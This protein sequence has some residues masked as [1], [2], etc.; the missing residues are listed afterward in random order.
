M[1]FGVWRGCVAFAVLLVACLSFLWIS[2]YCCLLGV[3][4]LVWLA[5]LLLVLDC[6]F[7]LGIVIWFLGFVV[8]LV[9]VCLVVL[10]RVL[11]SWFW[12]LLLL[13]ICG[14]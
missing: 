11:V 4:V 3:W 7:D 6:R 2:V 14:F 5:L 8:C 12:V 1:R 10:V 9:V 13:C